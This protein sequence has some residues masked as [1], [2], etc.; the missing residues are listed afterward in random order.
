M[1]N[2]NSVF[3]LSQHTTQP[4]RLVNCGIFP[5][6]KPG[7]VSGKCVCETRGDIFVADLQLPISGHGLAVFGFAVN[8]AGGDLAK[9]FGQSEHRLNSG[10]DSEFHSPSFVSLIP[11]RMI[12]R[13]LG[14]PNC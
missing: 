14:V 6:K 10:D 3:R 12:D 13:V 11:P 9:L 1:R 8:T 2:G 4:G 7:S 5:I